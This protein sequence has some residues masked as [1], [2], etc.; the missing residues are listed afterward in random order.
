MD[1]RSPRLIVAVFA[2]LL[3]CA[4]TATARAAVDL[5]WRPAKQAALVGDVVDI[6]LYAVSDNQSDQTV[7]A[8]GVILSWDSAALELL[9]KTDD[10][11]FAWES[12]QF[13]DD[14]GLDGLNAP[15]TGSDPFVPTNDGDALYRALAP[16]ATP[17]AIATPDGFLVATLHFRALAGGT[18]QLAML[19]S[20]GAETH[21]KV[22]H[23]LFPGVDVTGALGGPA[24]IEI[25]QPLAAVH[26]DV[27]AGGG[28]TW[29]DA[30][31]DLASALAAIPAT[32][33]SAEV[34]LAAGTYTPAGPDGDRAASF[35]L[36]SGVAIYGGFAGGE[37]SLSE[38][39]PTANRTVLSGD[40]N[41]DDDDLLGSTDENSYHVVT[42]GGADTTAT[43]DGVLV[44]GGNADGAAPD[45]RGAGLYNA[46][47][48]PTITN[49]AFV[50]NSAAFG[51]GIF[52]GQGAAPTLVNCV[53]SGNAAD[54]GAA[55]YSDD[56]NATLINCSLSGNTATTTGGVHNAGTTGSDATI[57]NCVLWGNTDG[58]DL[59]A[60]QV[61][62]DAGSTATVN[63]SCIQGL[64]GALG[65]TGNIGDDPLFADADLRLP[66]GSPANDAGQNAAVPASVTSDAD[67]NPRF[68]DDPTVADSGDG[69]APIV[70]MGAF[71]QF[72][73][74]NTNGI[75]DEVD[76]AQGTSHD[77]NANGVPDECDIAAGTSQDCQ[78][79]GVPDECNDGCAPPGGG[80]GGGVVLP[81]PDDDGDGVDDAQDNCPGVANATQD[82]ADEDGVGDDC[83]NC[84]ADANDNQGD[85][86]ED[87]V[88]NVCDNC[89]SHANANQEDEDG[90][91]LGDACDAA[92]V[93]D[94]PDD[95]GDGAPDG[96]DNCED[97]AN[98]DQ[99][100]ADEDGVGDAC[101]NC[102]EDANDDQ[103]DG[104]DDGVGDACDNCVEV[105]NADQADADD[106]GA[107]D[108]CDEPDIV[109]LDGDGVDEADDNCR[110]ALNADQADADEDGV[111]DACD[112]CADDANDD[113]AD[114]DGDGVGDACDNCLDDANADQADEDEDGLGDLCDDEEPE[115]PVP[116]V[117]GSGAA[118]A[119]PCG[120]CGSGIPIIMLPLSL[121]MWMTQRGRFNR[122]R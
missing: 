93:V 72:A 81:P 10:G 99:T 87:G 13:P 7:G 89:P 104:D 83:D 109:D 112:N 18:A 41:G 33:C 17:P 80:G 61:G 54:T 120:M 82:D 3:S 16:I 121:L 79:N 122:R 4:L 116:N 85:R 84:V 22:S 103:A 118:A 57:T 29:G 69:T 46:A 91:G 67:G 26:V 9:G 47:G 113:Q 96:A 52:N 106:D 76:I 94:I 15:F 34:W 51:G 88:G 97:V 32:A 42:G 119:A 77:C 108:A 50:G 74:C 44:T 43:L 45:D 64:S 11:T 102:V 63:Y 37:A 35:E 24:E 30:Y 75:A 38:R 68:L 73:D 14:S 59:E 36:K 105:A 78:L 95:D 90:D 62:S 25:C 58:V 65:G 56:S 71:E 6:G 107:G 8:V 40:L 12:S 1:S 117:D 111:G 27:N 55:V 28:T 5:E 110:E 23:G 66:L 86:D 31:P 21:T 115:Q 39:D 19:S 92:P 100:D 60:A 114:T 98:A 53:L 20:F 49:T 2:A 70:D 101:D 48:S